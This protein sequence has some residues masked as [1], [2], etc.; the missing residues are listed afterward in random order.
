MNDKSIFDAFTAFQHKPQV[1]AAMLG[2][3]RRDWVAGEAGQAAEQAQEKMR[4]YRFDVLP[5]QEAD[6]Q[7]AGYFR[8]RKVGDFN[9][10]P[11]WCTIDEAAD[12]LPYKT[13]LLPLLKQL[14]DKRNADRAPFYFLTS[15]EPEGPQE[16]VGMVADV[17]LNSRAVFQYGYAALTELEM[18]LSDLIGAAFP[19]ENRLQQAL[20]NLAQ[21]GFAQKSIE[22]SLQSFAN[23]SKREQQNTLR[24]YLNLRSM[25]ALVEHTGL[26][27]WLGYAA[28][29]AGEF[30]RKCNEILKVRNWV[31]HPVH[32]YES[33]PRNF[34]TA[35]PAVEAGPDLLATRL[36]T[37]FSAVDTMVRSLK[38]LRKF[39]D[40]Q[41]DRP[42]VGQYFT[43]Q[44]FS[45]A[46][47][48]DA[49]A[50][51][52]FRLEPGVA[53]PEQLPANSRSIAYLTSQNPEPKS[54]S[55]LAVDSI[56]NQVHFNGLEDEL[57]AQELVAWDVAAS[58]ARADEQF[59]AIR[60][61]QQANNMYRE[62]GCWLL[63]I[64][65]ETACEWGRRYKQDAIVYAEAGKMAQLLA[66]G[67]A[68]KV[69][70]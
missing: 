19:E 31:A 49:F 26:Y 3:S 29:N 5:V 36:Y 48:G 37:A 10:L 34:R 60:Q 67:K 58:Q 25:L 2:I 7:V 1:T 56:E 62:D 45:V 18:E 40:S 17:N 64:T 38:S 52:A 9:Q 43:S 27:S 12:C 6:G 21:A 42:R 39:T 35:T 50:E 44:F 22:R 69:N 13:G 59:P 20:D 14:A 15:S 28:A 24:E 4:A 41:N 47:K 54:G 63:N 11:E 16:I 70:Q 32:S 51:G 23:D 68:P 65:P 61:Q 66:C 46:Q 33:R 55:W 8:T 53:A 57:K 30:S